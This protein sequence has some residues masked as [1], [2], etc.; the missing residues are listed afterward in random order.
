MIINNP[1]LFPC[2]IFFLTAGGTFD[3]H[4]G[5]IGITYEQMQNFIE[6]VLV[7]SG[8]YDMSPNARN[9]TLPLGPIMGSPTTI[10][11]N[12]I[13]DSWQQNRYRKLLHNTGSLFY[14]MSPN[15]GNWT[16]HLGPIMS[17]P[18]AIRRNAV[19]DS[20]QQNRY[21]TFIES[22]FTGSSYYYMS[23]NSRN[24]TMTDTESSFI[25]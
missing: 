8:Y 3:P 2:A 17:S 14:D 4:D 21:R 6:S 9:R 19:S 15:A 11:R 18:T 7:E 22:F 20:W 23:P 1:N 16:L 12:A 10:R 5:E 25:T 13:S 24:W